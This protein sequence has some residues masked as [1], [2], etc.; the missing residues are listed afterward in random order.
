MGSSRAHM[1]VLEF[2]RT[3]SSGRV[4][5]TADTGNSVLAKRT[6]H[7]LRRRGAMPW[8]E[9][10]D[11][12]AIVDALTAVPGK[13]ARSSAAGNAAH[14][15]TQL[16]WEPHAESTFERDLTLSFVQTGCTV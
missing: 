14:A 5:A 2:L 15:S 1:A 4:R 6:T 13:S 8:A 11:G 16:C 9:V 7:G 3:P 12:G 10:G